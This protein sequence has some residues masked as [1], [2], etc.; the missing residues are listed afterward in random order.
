M[1][2]LPDNSLSCSECHGTGVKPCRSAAEIHMSELA[3]FC[4]CSHGQLRW[5]ATL[6]RLSRVDKAGAAFKEESVDF[7]GMRGRGVVNGR[8]AVSAAPNDHARYWLLCRY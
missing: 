5:T 8:T 4:S 3:T 1:E 2:T 6:Q 7:D